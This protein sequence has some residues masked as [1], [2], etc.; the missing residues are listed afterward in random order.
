MCSELSSV[1]RVSALTW[2]SSWPFNQDLLDGVSY[3]FISFPILGLQQLKSQRDYKAGHSRLASG[4]FIPDLGSQ[5][6]RKADADTDRMGKGKAVP[7]EAG[8]GQAQTP[9]CEGTGIGQRVAWL[10]TR[11]DVSCLRGSSS[12][13]PQALLTSPCKAWRVRARL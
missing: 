3:I 4:S 8:H 13:Q 9:S 6:Q 5:V 10:S 1:Y 7:P 2:T 11:K 12:Q